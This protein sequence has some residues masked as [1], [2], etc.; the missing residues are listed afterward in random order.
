MRR[1]F[2]SHNEGH[3]D[4]HECGQEDVVFGEAG[5]AV[6]FVAGGEDQAAEQANPAAEPSRCDRGS[7]EDDEHS[8][9]RGRKAD[10][11]DGV[12]A[13]PKD[14]GNGDGHPMGEGRSLEPGAAAA[15]GDDEVVGS[16]H[17]ARQLGE[18]AFVK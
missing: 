17:L 3:G 16:H 4:H 12:A 9:K 13:L 14:C 6:E 5:V 10:D 11:P 7:E 18:T 2:G 15:S 1:E 8:A